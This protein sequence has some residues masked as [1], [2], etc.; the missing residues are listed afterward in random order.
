MTPTDIEK[1]KGH[2]ERRWRHKNPHQ[3]PTP[4]IRT[5]LMV[6]LISALIRARVDVIGVCW[7]HGRGL[8]PQEQGLYLVQVPGASCPELLLALSHQVQGLLQLADDWVHRLLQHEATSLVQAA[9]HGTGEGRAS[10]I[11]EGRDRAGKGTAQ[12]VGHDQTPTP[13]S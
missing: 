13:G 1:R 8:C 7:D 2:C 9:V 6:V 4:T 12:P 11:D 10:C 3:Q 5:H